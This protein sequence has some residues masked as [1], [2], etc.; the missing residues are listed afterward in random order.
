M[1]NFHWNYDTAILVL[2]RGQIEH[3][4]AARIE[5]LVVFFLGRTGTYNEQ[6]PYEICMTLL[7]TCQMRT[8]LSL[9]SWW[10]IPGVYEAWG[11]VRSIQ[12][13]LVTMRQDT[14]GCRYNAVQYEIILHTWLQWLRQHRKKYF[15][16]TIGTCELRVAFVSICRKLWRYYGTALYCHQNGEKR[17]YY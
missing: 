16:L 17:G 1:R 14:A 4:G 11:W 13:A 9:P 3:F 5:N 7:A 8:N 12:P 2:S 6:L 10:Y 15:L